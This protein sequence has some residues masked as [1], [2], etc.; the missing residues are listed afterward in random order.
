MAQKV[1]KVFGIVLLLVGV[2]GFFND[3]VLGIFDVDLEHN[4]IHL[5]SGILALSFGKT[6]AG[7]KKFAK[8]F[9]V[10]YGLVALAGLFMGSPILSLVDANTADHWLHVALAVIFLYVGFSGDKSSATPSNPSMGQG[11]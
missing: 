8:I 2:L 6:A 4:L 1:V 3:P 5:V 11:M 7:A 9:G 10:V